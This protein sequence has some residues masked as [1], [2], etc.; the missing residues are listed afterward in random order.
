LKGVASES[1]FSVGL[2][3]PSA[4]SALSITLGAHGVIL[5]LR[6]HGIVL[7]LGAHG[8]ILG[9]GAH[10]VILGLE[11]HCKHVKFTD[12]WEAEVL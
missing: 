9:P 6:A 3:L 2:N 8:V 7:G 11:A 10:G 1:S 4:D 12:S 5:G